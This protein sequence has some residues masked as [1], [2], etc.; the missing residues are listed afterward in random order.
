ME[1]CD[2]MFDDLTK[3]FFHNNA[4]DIRFPIVV[5]KLCNS[6]S[7]MVRVRVL[8]RSLQDVLSIGHTGGVPCA[9][10]L[11][12]P[13]NRS[14]IL[15]HY[16]GSTRMVVECKLDMQIKLTPYLTTYYFYL[17]R[18]IDNECKLDIKQNNLAFCLMTYSY[19]RTIEVR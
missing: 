13:S 2:V 16:H 4:I 6:V 11:L 14:G 5:G 10:P 17:N 3:Y 1:I 19:H 8:T 7:K 15:I 12:F 18:R 9:L